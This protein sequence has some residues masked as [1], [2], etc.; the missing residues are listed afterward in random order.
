MDSRPLGTNRQNSCAALSRDHSIMRSYASSEKLHRYRKTAAVRSSCCG[1]R[2]TVVTGRRQTCQFMFNFAFPQANLFRKRIWGSGHWLQRV[3]PAR[4][5]FVL[6]LF[7]KRFE[8]YHEVLELLWSA[9]FRV[10]NG[11]LGVVAELHLDEFVQ[12]INA[13]ST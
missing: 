2:T 7:L 11:L 5:E 13:R 1:C 12:A 8:L 4:W 6:Q 10:G 9:A 3:V